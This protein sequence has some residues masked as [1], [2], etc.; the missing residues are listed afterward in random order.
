MSANFLSKSRLR[1]QIAIFFSAAIVLVS[2]F[3]YTYTINSQHVV[4]REQFINNQR[5][6]LEYVLLSLEYVLEEEN[7]EKIA[8]VNQWLN[9][10][11]SFEFYIVIDSSNVDLLRVPDTINK[12]Y[13]TLMEM[14]ADSSVGAKT[15]VMH[16]EFVTSK[17]GKYDIFLGFS[18]EKL[19]K[20][21]HETIINASIRTL[22]TLILGV[23]VVYLISRSITDPLVKL[24]L[25]ARRIADG[26]YDRRADVDSGGKEIRDLAQS[27]NTMI[28]RILESQDKLFEEMSKYN[29]SLDEQ[30]SNLKKTNDALQKEIE[31]RRKAESAMKAAEN[32]S[33][34]LIDSAPAEFMFIDAESKIKLVNKAFAYRFDKRAEDIAGLDVDE[35]ME[36]AQAE[37]ALQKIEE[38]KQARSMV[39]F[40]K[41]FDSA[42]GANRHYFAA[43]NPHYSESGEFLG[44][45]FVALD[46]TE[47]K[48]AE[49]TLL[50]ERSL[51]SSLID[52][53]PDLIF[54]KDVEGVYLG[55]NKA[56][57]A[58]VGKSERDMVGKNDFDLFAPKEAAYYREKDQ[59]LLKYR[60]IRRY[61]EWAEYPDGKKA[62]LDTIKTPFFDRE[63]NA[64]GLIGISRDITDQRKN[65]EAF[66]ESEQ[67]FRALSESAQDGIIIMD[68][69]GAISFWNQAAQRIFGYSGEEA[70]GADLHEL[71]APE[72]SYDGFHKGIKRFVET[73]EGVVIGKT[74]ELIGVR[75]DG[76]K[77]S[78]ELSIS[79]V[80]MQNKWNAIGISRDVTQRKAMELELQRAKE[81]AE[82]ANKAKSEFLAN[83]S[84]EI[85][86]PMNAI[87]GFSQLL[88][89]K[90]REKTLKGYVEAI[91]SSGK[92]LLSL[93]NDILDL[94]KIEAGKLELQ[95]D[96]VNPYNIF[97][98]IK[99][100][101]S[102]KIEEKGLEFIA[103]MDKEIPR[104][105]I[106]DEIRLRQ[107]LVNLVGNALKFT[108][109]GFIKISVSKEYS[110]DDESKLNLSFCVEDTGIG[111]SSDQQKKIF[112]AFMQQSGQSARKYGGTGLGLAITRRLVE[113]MNGEISVRSEVGKGSAFTVTIKDVAVS[114]TI[115][116][117]SFAA[118]MEFKRVRFAGL[119][120][121]LVDDIEINRKLIREYF[122]ESDVEFSEAKNG[123]EAIQIAV[124][125]KPDLILMDMKMPV[126]DGYEATRKIR[127]IDELTNT[128][129]IALTASAMKGDEEK[130]KAAG[131]NG[132]QS[133]PIEK[134]SL[135]CEIAN[136]VPDKVLPDEDEKKADASA[137][138]V[139][140]EDIEFDDNNAAELIAKIESEF[141]PRSRRL[142]QSLI[143][144]AV[145]EFAEELRE[146]AEE[147]GVK[148]I[149]NYAVNLN[150]LSDNFDLPGIRKSLEYFPK[151]VEKIKEKLS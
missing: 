39:S 37:I 75:K 56:Y 99:N 87:L 50:K 88:S 21:K 65:Q 20:Q 63:G 109:T 45:V 22:I 92:S 93:I 72:G 27:F 31:E 140:V 148:P 121:L 5:T 107:I 30:N 78:I 49:E 46:V 118:D 101:F 147:F 52:S 43:L 80:Q 53:I 146:A 95:Y 11:E 58:F 12:S 62:L 126:M 60:K 94:S 3:F 136:F 135:L 124:K 81:D 83:M 112:E 34:A 96:A 98:E 90:I 137:E 47:Q 35:V 141:E 138:T 129:I 17:H 106:L 74:L 55:C 76:E 89:G 6:T 40:E 114:S 23:G 67:R 4:F 9:N 85:R 122:E 100:I 70:L 119:R 143:I 38:A 128:P 13:E 150:E 19:S 111:I 66:R 18:T 25:V 77:I 16:K 125:E 102:F 8:S 139:D 44:S 15:K 1:V 149:A 108:D 36:P 133:K 120:I 28:Q 73:G 69:E 2:A 130:I 42:L 116:E 103:Q 127:E 33:V 131:C 57:E 86:T 104:G 113:M 79:A 26:D 117:E 132:Y 61:E 91:S 110:D 142:K 51:L 14:A 68:P 105:L 29:R 151:L 123:K 144:G 32:L 41:S 97:N 115:G 71:L 145:N 7:Y 84:H 54:Y 48:R 59:E 10:T 24:S 82:A 64:L 134:N